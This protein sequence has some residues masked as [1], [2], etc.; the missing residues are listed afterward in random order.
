[1]LRERNFFGVREVQEYRRSHL[2]VLMHGTTEHGAQSTD[3]S[4]RG[5][6]LSYYSRQGPVGDA[7][8]VLSPRVGRSVAI[9]GLGAGTLAA[10]ARPGDHWVFYE[11]DPEIAQ[12]ARDTSYFTYLR[13]SPAK[14]DVV[15]GDGR[16][17]LAAAPARTY[18]ILVVD[19]FNS[20][21]IPI[22]LLTREALALYIEKLSDDG[23]MLFHLSN[24]YLDLEPVLGRLAQSAHLSAVVREDTK[25]TRSL[26]E[27]GATPSTWAA[28]SPKAISLTGLQHDPQWRQLRVSGRVRLWTDDFSNIFTVFRWP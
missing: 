13:D 6:P 3:P 1:L 2:H 18:D 12:L 8:R 21:A 25:R 26:V 22:H 17:S 15:L 19:A 4:K 9:I 14:V 11:I 7:F 5:I 27:A 10:Y 24:R 16:L 23:V 28:L 20:D